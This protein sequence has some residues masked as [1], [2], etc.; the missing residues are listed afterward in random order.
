MALSPDD[1]AQLAR[2]LAAVQERIAQACRAS[3]RDPAG[4]QLVAVTKYAHAPFAQALLELGQLDLGENRVQHLLE[5]DA[6]LDGDPRPRWH[7]IGHLQK[8]KVK[9]VAP[10]LDTL[11]TLDGE[12]LAEKLSAA[13]E[14]LPPLKVYLQ[15][16]LAESEGRAGAGSDELEPLW[17]RAC[18]LTGLEPLGLMGLPPRGAPEEAR[19]H[20]RRLRQAAGRLDT[21]QLS[22]GMTADLEVAIAEGATVVRVGS[23]LLEGLSDDARLP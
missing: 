9:A 16:K 14:G 23:A 21:Q 7:L 20:F 6:A 18:D 12:V 15:L 5:V 17:R 10:R 8:N 1:T 19:P 4:V 3:G 11:H 2:N 22:M 13:R